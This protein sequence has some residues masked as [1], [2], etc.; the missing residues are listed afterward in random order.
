MAGLVDGKVALVTGAGSGIGLACARLFAC[1]GARV[2]VSDLDEASG[3]AAAEAICT[4]GGEAKFVRCDVRD[5]AQVEQLIRAASDTYGRLD[6]A[7]NNAGGPAGGGPVHAL[8]LEDW[9][10]TLALNLSGVFLCM[11]HEIQVMQAQGGGSIVNTASGA[12]VVATP[13]LA[14]YSA[15]KHGVLGLTKTAARENAQTNVRINAVLP[16]SIDT[17]AL[18]AW[19]DQG[20]EV[21]KGILRSQPGGRLG[22]PEEIAEA[23]VWLS[24]DR[25]SFVHGESMMVDGG[26]I[27]R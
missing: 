25:A 24:S 22:L 26:A 17:P 5:E 14:H 21:A 13:F 15:A 23:V 19:M 6:C 1:E 8:S 27:S 7:H 10:Q 3:E 20:P 18:R 4:D 11:K 16:G 9:N 2:I 12:G